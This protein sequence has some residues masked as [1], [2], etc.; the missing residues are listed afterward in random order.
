VEKRIA[1]ATARSSHELVF[2][3]LVEQDGG[4]PK[5]H[6]TPP[7]IFHEEGSAEASYMDMV[8]SVLAR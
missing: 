7:P 1:K 3:K 5:I 8:A 6:D 2:P 4:T